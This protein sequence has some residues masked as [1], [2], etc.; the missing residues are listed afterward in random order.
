MPQPAR[1]PVARI[2][3]AVLLSGGLAITGCNDS[4]AAAR[5]ETD[6]A[7]AR[8]SSELQ[9]AA[10]TTDR[11]ADVD[12]AVR[13]LQS[14]ASEAAGISAG[15][16]QQ[17]ASA[18]LLASDAH[19]KLADLHLSLAREAE[20]HA[21]N[22]RAA[23]ESLVGAASRINEM[24]ESLAT[25]DI[26]D[27]RERLTAGINDV[28]ELIAD[29]Q[30]R[31]DALD[32][33]IAERQQA[34]VADRGQAEELNRDANEL[35]REAVDAGPRRG[36]PSY[37]AAI[38]LEQEA[39]GFEFN[40]ARRENELAHDYFPNFA[41]SSLEVKEG[42]EAIGRLEDALT[43]VNDREQLMQAATSELQNAIGNFRST[44][45]GWLTASDPSTLDELLNA[46][47]EH[48]E[49]AASLAGR[50]RSGDRS[51]AAAAEARATAT[52][53]DLYSTMAVSRERHAAVVSSASTV[54]PL[55]VPAS[56]A[57]RLS[58]EAATARAKAIE[59]FTGL[60][61]GS[62]GDQNLA[63]LERSARRSIE[64]LGGEAPAGG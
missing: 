20:A 35:R 17:K 42:E 19:R 37:R 64:R 16:V 57:S 14:I 61:E 55:N 29:A 31:V 24:A 59:A 32:G 40:V 38:E 5:A 47:I 12:E 26:D 48:A 44:L 10:Y 21:N 8:L 63:A 6:S 62:G 54:P 41:F 23:A 18:A 33:P 39:D 43:S 45:E 50:A 13:R 51:S 56:D 46:G 49:Q 22:E 7:I 28:N 9:L 34:N 3:A 58:G 27:A 30:S 4:D 52:L 36:L 2:C 15:S 25:I 60:I 11:Q 1:L 53:G